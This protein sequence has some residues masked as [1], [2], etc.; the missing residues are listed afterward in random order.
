MRSLLIGLYRKAATLLG[1]TGIS[2]VFPFNVIE[3]RLLRALRSPVAVVD[4]HTMHLDAE[5]SL[6]LSVCG[7]FEPFETATLKTLVHEGDTIVDVGANIGFYT[8]L[9]A[10]LVGDEGRVYAFEPD[11]G[12]FALLTKN[13][14]VNGYQ[15]VTAVQAAVSE[16]S[17]SAKLFLAKGNHVDHK[18]YDTE[19]GRESV[20]VECCRLDDY[21]DSLGPVQLIKMD[22]QGAEVGAV[23]GM[24]G[25]LER[26]AGVTVVTEFWPFGLES[27]G[28]S[29]QTYLDLLGSMGFEVLEVHEPTESI[30]PVDPTDLLER[31]TFA[32]GKFT[33]LLCR[34]P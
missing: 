20:E 9:F 6:N 34:R 33:N 8:L 3:R 15:N 4:G 16:E 17:G 10:R 31:L 23:Q 2:Q 13:I 12:N 19:E 22:I 32:N 11:P 26:S 1:G 30:R 21:F 5:D 18:L 24:Q 29:P 27:A 28:D 7:N 14:E 25:L